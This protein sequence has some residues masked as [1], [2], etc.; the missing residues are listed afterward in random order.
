VLEAGEEL[1]VFFDET[2]TQTLP[3][4][5]FHIEGRYI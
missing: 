3:V 2:G 5:R 4:G 1:E